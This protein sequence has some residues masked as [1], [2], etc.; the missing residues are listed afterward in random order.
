MKYITFWRES[1]KFADILT[2]NVIKKAVRFKI[3]WHH[4]LLIGIQDYDSK[5]EQIISYIT[6]KYGDDMKSEVVPDRSPII[7][8]DYL[9]KR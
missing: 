2:D 5:N 8:V 3:A 7:G 6:L 9:P 4:Y 1:N